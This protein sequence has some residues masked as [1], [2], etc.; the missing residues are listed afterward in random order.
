MEEEGMG[1]KERIEEKLQE[2]TVFKLSVREYKEA[3]FGVETPTGRGTE[4]NFIIL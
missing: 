2:V 1:D 4:N 3:E